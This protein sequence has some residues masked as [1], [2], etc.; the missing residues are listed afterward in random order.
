MSPHGPDA[1]T[2]IKASEEQ[3]QVRAYVHMQ[4]ACVRA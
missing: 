2:F 1:D 3:L 4:A